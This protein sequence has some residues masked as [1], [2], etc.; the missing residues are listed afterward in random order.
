MSWPILPKNRI[1]AGKGFSPLKFLER[2]DQ[3]KLIDRT[4]GERG[5]SSRKTIGIPPGFEKFRKKGVTNG[6]GSGEI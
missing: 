2:M 6:T 5:K 4:K 1:R 3:G